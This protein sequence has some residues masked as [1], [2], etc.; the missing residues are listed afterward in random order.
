MSNPK[1]FISYSWS[2]AEHEGWV[3]LLGKAL[4]NNGVNVI[5]DKWDLKEGNDANVFMEKMVSDD[6]IKKV[7]LVIDEQYS[8]KAKNRVG[9]V[10]KEAQIISEELYGSVDQDKF[11]A[12]IAS[13]DHEGNINLPP[14][15]KSRIYI[16]LS[17][18]NLYSEKFETLLRWA[19]N[20]PLDK[21]PELGPRPNFA[22]PTGEVIFESPSSLMQKQD[23][24]ESHS[25]TTLLKH[26]Y[27]AKPIPSFLD[28][29]YLRLNALIVELQKSKND[30]Y[31]RAISLVFNC[32]SVVYIKPEENAFIFKLDLE[33]TGPN[34][35][36]QV[37]Y[38]SLLLNKQAVLFS[39]QVGNITE[40]TSLY[41]PLNSNPNNN[42][43]CGLLLDNIDKNHSIDD[44]CI[45]LIKAL[46]EYSD[47]FT[48][49]IQVHECKKFTLDY[50]K[51][52]LN[53]VSDVMYEERFTLFQEDLQSIHIEFESIVQFSRETSHFNT[54]GVEALARKDGSAP[55]GI[56]KAAE[57]W[58]VR[59]QT[60]LDIFIVK[61]TLK[62]YRASLNESRKQDFNQILPI[63]INVYPNTILREGF[64]TELLDAINKYRIQG[65][66]IILEISEKE[67]ITTGDNENGSLNKFN[68]AK[69]RLKESNINFAIDD[70]GAGHSSLLRVQKIMPDFV[71]IDRDMLI[72]QPKIAKQFIKQLVRF[73]SENGNKLFKII[74]EGVDQ[75]TSKNISIDELVNELHVEYIQGH[76]LGMTSKD[77]CYRIPK[78]KYNEI[79][80]LLNWNEPCEIE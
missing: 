66:K 32:K 10:G 68:Q 19:Y 80:K 21:R 13:R 60:E 75:I 61:K 16:D 25:L 22:R 54:W 57:L 69:R 37:E 55:V 28:H 67:M 35:W 27:Q 4:R 53:F 46:Y 42:A 70:F 47:D 44:C 6:D 78:S 39:H 29:S 45:L 26:A 18:K 8:I 74:V 41:I 15:Y 3:L 2:S 51:R 7:I 17:D 58:G 63:S 38:Q 5:L 64:C 52:Y 1:L 30:S 79:K 50:F 59:F 14:Y 71:K 73:D 9:G 24:P 56:F 36:D 11:V 34:R 48:K 12:V 40:C 23:E 20:E 76:L 65:D 49:T 72:Y 43:N 33:S 31:F 77:V 62:T